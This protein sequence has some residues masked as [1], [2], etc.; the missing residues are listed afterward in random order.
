M[1]A[2]FGYNGNFVRIRNVTVNPIDHY[3]PSF[4]GHAVGLLAGYSV[5]SI[6]L[7]PPPLALSRPNR[8]V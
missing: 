5:H 4:C 6:R 7:L 2:R 8:K 3:D 1:R